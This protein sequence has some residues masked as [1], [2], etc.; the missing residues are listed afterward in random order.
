MSEDVASRWGSALVELDE[1]SPSIYESSGTPE[2]TVDVKS[3]EFG[4]DKV[5][6]SSM[7]WDIL[8]I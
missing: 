2:R 7:F 8:K 5:G 4:V 3:W 1:W 6:T